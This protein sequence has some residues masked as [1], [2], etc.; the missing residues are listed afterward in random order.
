MFKI[1]VESDP[2]II[3]PHVETACSI[4]KT[5]LTH[6]NIQDASISL[7]FAGDELL[8]TLK[9]KF[10]GLEQFTDVIAF[11]LND[12]AESEVEG[13]I[14]ISLPRATENAQKYAEPVPREIARLIIHGTLHLLNYKDGTA[15][16]KKSMSEAEEKYLKLINWKELIQNDTE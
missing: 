6:K 12:Y 9:Q 4:I 8:S 13:E 5:V 3:S 1:Q 11:R 7:I 15:V 2:E 10:F 16:E 14:Y